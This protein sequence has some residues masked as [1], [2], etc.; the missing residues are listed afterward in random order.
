MTQQPHAEVG[1]SL[2]SPAGEFDL[3]SDDLVVGDL[4]LRAYAFPG[5]ARD[6]RRAL[7]CIPGFSASG[8]SFARLAPLATTWDVRMVSGPLDQPYPGNPVDSLAGVIVDYAS[9]F[10][11]PV[12]LGTSFGG[13]VAI[14]AAL[15]MR[16]AISGLILTAAFAN[17]ERLGLLPF[18]RQLIPALQLA[19]APLAPITARVV[20][21]IGIDPA[22]RSAIVEDTLSISAAERARR[23]RAIFSTNLLGRLGEIDAPTLVIHG[24]RDLLVPR[25]RALEMAEALPDCD[26]HEI[27]GAGHLPYVTHAEEF[28]RLAS[29]FLEKQVIGHRS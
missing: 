26:Y 23:L 21:G 8:R 10:E 25:A 12:I 9:Q 22:G 29:A 3:P 6:P 15:R 7:I 18:M 11:R 4:P 19:A 20:G 14:N 16:G 2:R 1:R 28:V 17:G 5:G 24:L 27:P 13:L